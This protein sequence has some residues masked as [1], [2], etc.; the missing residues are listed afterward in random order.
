MHPIVSCFVKIQ[1]VVFTCPV[2][3][4]S[5]CLAKEAVDG[6]L[7]VF[8]KSLHV[9]PVP[10][11]N[12]QTVLDYRSLFLSAS[13]YLFQKTSFCFFKQLSHKS[14][15]FSIFGTHDPEEM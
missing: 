11:N 9:K 13:N 6:Y 14:A 5:G 7:S 3:P 10:L 8:M 15:S 1:V 4:Y 12:V 2:P